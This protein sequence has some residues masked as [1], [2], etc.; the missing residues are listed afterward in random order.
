MQD[1]RCVLT[2]PFYRVGLLQSRGRIQ[3]QPSDQCCGGSQQ[4][5]VWRQ[6][7]G[8]H[9]VQQSG[10]FRMLLRVLALKT[11]STSRSLSVTMSP[12]S[13]MEKVQLMTLYRIFLRHL[14]GSV[15]II[16]TQTVLIL[17]LW[18]TPSPC[19]LVCALMK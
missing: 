19:L 13:L 6:Q 5:H 4:T 14:V 15:V 18:L 7:G 16:A 12:M 1:H 11:V 8:R 10:L 17:S 2:V 3:L 9:E